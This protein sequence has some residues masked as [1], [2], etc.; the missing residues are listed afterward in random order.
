MKKLR[1]KLLNLM[2][3]LG[4]LLILGSGTPAFAESYHTA[5]PNATAPPEIKRTVH[6]LTIKNSF[7]WSD[8][9]E[10]DNADPGEGF[11]KVSI[12]TTNCVLN[13]SPLNLTYGASGA[14]EGRV[15][16]G[17][18][19]NLCID[20]SHIF[21]VVD[22]T[23]KN[24]SA[25]VG[26]RATYTYNIGATTIRDVLKIPVLPDKLTYASCTL[27]TTCSAWYSFNGIW[28]GIDGRSSFVAFVNTGNEGNVRLWVTDDTTGTTTNEN[29]YLHT[30]DTFYEMTTKVAYGRLRM[31]IPAP[32]VGGGGHTPED[33]TPKIYAVLFRGYKGAGVA[34]AIVPT[35]SFS[36]SSP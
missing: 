5:Q 18:N 31:T 23:I 22:L 10:A 12:G 35:L 8:A 2:A 11:D 3:V 36:A 34:Q 17:F 28:N 27:P 19:G 15:G 30:G 16:L 33:S 4:S 21:D 6:V 1:N 26:T 7:G 14:F 13:S 25:D 32:T 24:G 29:V 20:T 9:L